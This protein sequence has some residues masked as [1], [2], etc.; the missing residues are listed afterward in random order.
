MRLQLPS[1][2]RYAAPVVQQQAEIVSTWRALAAQHA[3]VTAALER[4]LGERHG[5]GVTEFEVLERLAENDEHKFRVQELA[6]SV[7]LS[8]SAL[9]RMIGR[10]E[11]HGLVQRSMC[12]VD[13]RGID[14]CLTEAG[15]L[16]HA[17]A[18]PTQRAVLAATL[19]GQASR[20]P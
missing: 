15:R 19:A 1:G 9:S 2:S 17:E 12:D 8:Q 20:S 18:L 5:L 11:Q 13:R 14:V 10:L 7:H 3:A 16:R 6:E 4:E